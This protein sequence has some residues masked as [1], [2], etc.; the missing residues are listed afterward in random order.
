M[1]QRFT[2]HST[3]KIERMYRATLERVFAAWSEQ[4]AKARWFQPAEEFDFRVGGREVS[5]GGPPGG[6]VFTFDALYQEIVPNE[7][8]VYTYSLDQEDIRIS[9]SI[10]TVEF[11]PTAEGVKLVFTEQGVFF[12]GHDT[13]AQREQGTHE[14]LDLLGISL[15][16]SH[17]DRF[18]LL[19]RRT[20]PAPRSLVYRAWT[21][22]ALLAQW[23]GP[24]GFTNTFHTFDASPGGIWEFTMHGPEGANFPNRNVF[25]E[26]SEDR[27][28]LRHESRPHF[29]LTAT[30]ADVSG[31]TEITF[32]QTFETAEDYNNLKPI[33]EEANE[34]NLDRLRAVLKGLSS[35]D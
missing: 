6:P 14:M 25:H 20:L 3:F 19:S 29:I 9:V 34:Q 17:P 5:R 26:V 4:N 2:T 32:R 30:F 33:C 28:V 8:L 21:E 27:I 15:G 22:P 7:R 23:W 16:E 11:M 13:P 1:S 31:G 10:A 12:D 24:N 18:E 35:A